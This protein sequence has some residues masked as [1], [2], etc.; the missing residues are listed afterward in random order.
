MPVIVPRI[1][2]AGLVLKGPTEEVRLKSRREASQ[3]I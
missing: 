2:S 3:E 1:R